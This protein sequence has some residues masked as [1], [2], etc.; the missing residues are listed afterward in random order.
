MA[1]IDHEAE[2]KIAGFS[3]DSQTI[4]T[5]SNE[6]TEINNLELLRPKLGNQDK[7]MFP[8]SDLLNSEWENSFEDVSKKPEVRQALLGHLRSLHLFRNY[9]TPSYSNID[10][11][12]SSPSKRDLAYRRNLNLLTTR[13]Y[14]M[15][16]EGFLRDKETEI[17][18]AIVPLAFLPLAHDPIFFESTQEIFR[19]LLEVLS[20]YEQLR[21][22]EF[23]SDAYKE[24]DA[25]K[26]FFNNNGRLPIKNLRKAIA[27]S[28]QPIPRN[29]LEDSPNNLAENLAD[30][31]RTADQDSSLDWPQQYIFNLLKDDLRIYAEAK[32][33]LVHALKDQEDSI[34][35]EKFPSY[36]YKL[37][38]TKDVTEQDI[39]E[40]TLNP[41]SIDIDTFT[42]QQTTT[43]KPQ[44]TKLSSLL[45]G[46]VLDDLTYDNEF[47][48]DRVRCFSGEEFIESLSQEFIFE[49][50]ATD[51]VDG[52]VDDEGFDVEQI[53]NSLNEG[54]LNGGVPDNI[55]DIFQA[56]GRELSANNS[57]LTLPLNF[58]FEINESRDKIDSDIEKLNE[59]QIPED[60]VGG[61]K[62]FFN[63]YYIQLSSSLSLSVVTP[64]KEWEI[65]DNEA[66][67]E[68]GL[69]RTFIIYKVDSFGQLKL[70]IYERDR[71]RFSS[72]WWIRDIE[73]DKTFL[74]TVAELKEGD[75]G[76]TEITS[77]GVDEI[78]IA[79]ERPK[80]VIRLH[81][82][83]LYLPLL[84]KKS[85]GK[86]A[87]VKL[88]ARSAPSQALIVF[89][90]IF[91]GKT[92]SSDRQLGDREYTCKLRAPSEF[93]RLKRENSDDIDE[94]SSMIGV[95]EDGSEVVQS[96]LYPDYL[97][98][99]TEE[100]A[101]EHCENQGGAFDEEATSLSLCLPSLDKITAEKPFVKCDSADE[102]EFIRTPKVLSKR[103]PQ[104]LELNVVIVSLL[105]AV[106]ADEEGQ[107]QRDRLL[108]RRRP[109]VEQQNND[110]Q[111]PKILPPFTITEDQDDIQELR[112][113]GARA[114]SI[115][116]LQKWLEPEQPE[117]PNVKK[118]NLVDWMSKL[119]QRNLTLKEPE[120]EKW[121]D[122]Y[123]TFTRNDE[124]ED[125]DDKQK[126]I[127][128]KIEL[129]ERTDVTINSMRVSLFRPVFK[130][131]NE[132]S[133]N[134]SP[135]E[136]SKRSLHLV[137]VE[138]PVI[139][140][141]EFSTIGFRMVRNDEEDFDP[142][143]IQFSRPAQR[144]APIM[145]TKIEDFKGSL[146]DNRF[147]LIPTDSTSGWSIETFF[148]ELAKAILGPDETNPERIYKEPR[149]LYQSII[150]VSVYHVDNNPSPRL[151]FTQRDGGLTLGKRL[152]NETG[153]KR[154]F[155]EAKLVFRFNEP[156]VQAESRPIYLLKEHL[157]YWINIKCFTSNNVPFLE[158]LNIPAN[159]DI[160][161]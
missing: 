67:D 37:E 89:Q 36:F 10:V 148:I 74:I 103:W 93:S 160:T 149:K 124:E 46:D 155:S 131:D 5:A 41:L 141:E 34:S 51:V 45:I 112:E 83:V 134:E 7:F 99:W 52:E 20:S 114:V 95:R 4:V 92:M 91:G 100:S 64:G 161:L 63:R 82:N 110:G 75:D 111:T 76:N 78:T 6:T 119:V 125:S 79:E 21:L 142:R 156:N 25:W 29:D 61:E 84:G 117:D 11:N 19:L 24:V 9:L 60:F 116:R 109:P 72:E 143:F 147:L 132:N 137:G 121:S 80:P 101:R 22:D 58:I 154:P 23:N 128:N 115:E 42:Y 8:D 13:S 44:N 65:A 97:N 157:L 14:A 145:A 16:P 38:V 136:K 159:P 32:A 68:Q 133:P 3:P 144:P 129:P 57:F 69:K 71:E 105:I 27:R 86:D 30:Q 50:K 90:G 118:L 26:E 28:L 127:L 56:Y 113:N 55:R 54:I 17:R 94:P 66:V 98:I 33:L 39:N 104:M 31:W 62:R 77:L 15:A 73:N 151:G 107:L 126:P 81:E 48:V 35:L 12:S 49:L 108:I 153:Y 96:F 158:L 140:G 106:N 47:S 138:V 150:R 18:H 1:Q 40:E 85:P 43:Y 135:S 123:I 122:G 139:A 70:E 87:L 152:I 130:N 102:V 88:I 120:G 59:Q 146:P 53:I 2:I